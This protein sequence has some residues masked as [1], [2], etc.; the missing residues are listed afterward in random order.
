MKYTEKDEHML[1]VQY[2]SSLLSLVLF[3]VPRVRKKKT[4]LDTKPHGLDSALAG[5]QNQESKNC[6]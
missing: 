4:L 5:N 2:A 3:H 6:P 1:I